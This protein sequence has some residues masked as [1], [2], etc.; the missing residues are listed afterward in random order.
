MGV[1]KGVLKEEL[2]NSVRM[3]KNYERE[4]AKAAQRQPYQEESQ[5]SRISLS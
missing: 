4:L 3:K 1:I 5:G 2:E